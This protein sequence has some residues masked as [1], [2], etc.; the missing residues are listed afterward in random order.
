MAQP[1]K[2]I[3]QLRGLAQ[4][5]GVKWSFADDI[6]ALKQKIA[7]RQTELVPPPPLPVVAPPEDQRL[8]V[9][10]PSRVS[11]ERALLELLAPYI[12]LGLRVEIK[13]DIWSMKRGDITDTGTMR[14]PLRNVLGC[15]RRMFE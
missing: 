3:T 5:M 15:A 14:Q 7:M 11:E 1:P 12:S 6:A 4:S 2:S 13:D 8:R 10:P 9:K